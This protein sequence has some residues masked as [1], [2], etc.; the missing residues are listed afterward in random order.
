MFSNR[1]A[2]ILGAMMIAASVGAILARPTTKLSDVEQAISL[3]RVIPKRFGDWREEPRS[4]VQVVNPQTREMLDRLYSQVLSR[5]YVNESGYRVMLSIAYGNDQRGSLE[6][7]K[8]EVCYPAQ[9]FSLKSNRPGLL[10]TKFGNIPVRR[11]FATM[12]A[13][14]EQVTYWFT[15]GD[16]AVQGKLQ[17]RLAEL[18]YGLTGQIP[19]GLLFRVSSID[20]DAARA[21]GLQDRFVAQLLQTL[22]PAERLRLAGLGDF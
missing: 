4:H 11:L 17:K 13:R 20:P 12:G 15:I 18:R 14:E 3:E 19:D 22:S 16:T 8:P 9:G 6:A 1:V 2:V 10:A 21:N 5:I 7:H